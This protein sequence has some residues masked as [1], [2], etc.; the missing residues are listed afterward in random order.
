MEIVFSKNGIPIR[1]TDERLQ[2]VAQT[3]PEMKGQSQR[4]LD[5]IKR[6][7][8]I[9]LGDF[10]ELIA[11]RSFEKSPVSDNK[12]LHVVYKEVGNEDGF[13]ITAYYSRKYNRRRIVL[14]KP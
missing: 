14:W 6:P 2:H 7:D 3:P 12:F 9:L 1:L 13:L 5:T 8:M 10:G 11:I 4:I